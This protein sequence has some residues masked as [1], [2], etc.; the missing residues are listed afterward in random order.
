MEKQDNFCSTFW[1]GSKKMKKFLLLLN[2]KLIGPTKSSFVFHDH[3]CSPAQAVIFLTEGVASC[4][5][6]TV[7]SL[8][9]PVYLV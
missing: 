8:L 9:L 2:G 4:P 5:F 3:T 7:S 1:F 6:S